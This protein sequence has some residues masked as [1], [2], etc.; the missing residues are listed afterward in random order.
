ME[1]EKICGIYCIENLIDGKKY[2][3]QSVNIKKRFHDHKYKLR[4]SQHIND[5]LQRAWNKY[6]EDSFKFYILEECDKNKL[7]ELEVYYIN[8]YNSFNNGYNLSI[9]GNSIGYMSDITKQ[10]ISNSHK[11]KNLDEKEI[12]KMRSVQKSIPIYQIDMNGNIIKEWFGAREASKKLNINQSCI[13]ACLE[14]KRKSYLIYKDFIWIYKNEY[15]DFD[16][17]LYINRDEHKKIMQFTKNMEFIK[18][19]DFANQAKMDGFDQSAIIKCCKGKLKQHHGFV[20]KYKSE[21]I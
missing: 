18:E 12:E 3:G 2:I 5:F 21:I 16:L 11:N 8:I 15:N 17:N 19:W 13:R 10:K 6:N 14:N 20:F 1:K 7:N 9:G 4:K